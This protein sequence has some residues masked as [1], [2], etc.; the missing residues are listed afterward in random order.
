LVG[1]VIGVIIL[2]LLCMWRWLSGGVVGGVCIS[3]VLKIVLLKIRYI[4]AYIA[5][6][7]VLT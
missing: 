2:L 3:V 4:E 7:G 5:C 1:R 6:S